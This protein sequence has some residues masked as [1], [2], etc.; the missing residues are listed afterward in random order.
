MMHTLWTTAWL[1]YGV[2]FRLFIPFIACRTRNMISCGAYR[3][4]CENKYV[5]HEFAKNQSSGISHFTW[6]EYFKGD[7]SCAVVVHIART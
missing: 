6:K 3:V 7:K 5:Q 2:L 4:W 1:P